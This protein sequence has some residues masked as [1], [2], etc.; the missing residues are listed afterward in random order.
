MRTMAATLGRWGVGVS[1][2]F[3]GRKGTKNNFSVQIGRY[4]G[5]GREQT[6]IN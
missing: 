3:H 1:A 6:P 4:Q 2:L 5:A